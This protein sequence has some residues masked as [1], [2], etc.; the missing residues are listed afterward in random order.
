MKATAHTQCM[1]FSLIGKITLSKLKRSLPGAFLDHRLTFLYWYV[2][3]N[4]GSLWPTFSN[5]VMKNELKKRLRF[6][7][8]LCLQSSSSRLASIM[9]KKLMISSF[10]HFKARRHFYEHS[11]FRPKRYFHNS[12]HA[13]T[14]PGRSDHMDLRVTI[15]KS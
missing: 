2:P 15:S 3:S 14:C 7:L 1:P 11:I 10:S 9:R 4:E 6:R 5:L 12:A 8:G 13:L